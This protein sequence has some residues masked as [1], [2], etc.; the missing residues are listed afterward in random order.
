M[1]GNP[2]AAGEGVG[3]D[4][5]DLRDGVGVFLTAFGK[6]AETQRGSGFEWLCH[7]ETVAHLTGQ[8]FQPFLV[9]SRRLCYSFGVGV[10]QVGQESPTGSRL[11]SAALE[12]SYN[13]YEVLKPNNKL[14]NLSRCSRL[15]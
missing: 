6:M 4:C 3:I 8:G 9:F 10:A 15:K 14:A 7:S 5:C 12:M 11:Q 13:A 2:P 1:S